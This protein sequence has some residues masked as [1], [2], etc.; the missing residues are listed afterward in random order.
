M[1]TLPQRSPAATPA[2][3]GLALTLALALCGCERDGGAKPAPSGGAPAGASAAS[4][5]AANA[6]PAANAP[7]RIVATNLPL[8][9]FAGAIGGDAVRVELPV[10]E[11]EDPAD[12]MPSAEAVAAMQ[13]ADL[14]L[15]NGAGYEK[16]LATAALPRSR[17]LDLSAP[18]AASLLTLPEAVTHSHGPAGAHT[19][20]GTAVGVWLDFDLAA[21]QAEAVGARLEALR[22]AD[23]AAIRGRTQA[24]VARLHALAERSAAVGAALAGAPVIASHPVYDYLAR[25]A[26]LSLRS[27]HWEPGQEPTPDDWQAFDTLRA[28]H[29][30]RLMLWEGEP[31]RGTRDQ[32]LQRGIEVV[33]FAPG[34]NAPAAQRTL[35]AWCAQMEA[36]L[37]ALQTASARRRGS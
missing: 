32:L 34:P 37:D 13:G 7:L 18:V 16:W 8:F 2:T 6:P 25:R 15:C 28:A 22:P 36:A 30:A 26:G 29:P 21:K 33:V 3:A 23:A 31:S 10:P 24:L 12:W 11:G 27:V 1:S 35:D 9:L 4:G 20:T 17:T 5:A 14:I 19:H